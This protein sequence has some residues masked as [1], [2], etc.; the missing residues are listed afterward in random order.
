MT[1]DAACGG[2]GGREVTR[3]V[4]HGM[5]C[6]REEAM[7]EPGGKPGGRELAPRT[8]CMSGKYGSYGKNQQQ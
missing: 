5:A 3:G 4:L 8:F 7:T 1:R 2:Q 6:E